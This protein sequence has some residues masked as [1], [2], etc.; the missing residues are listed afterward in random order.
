MRR[1]LPLWLTAVVPGT[2]AGHA[3]AYALSGRTAAGG[4]HGWI[5]PA[6]EVSAAVLLALT[7]TLIGGHL[8]RAR[9]L[10]HTL[11]ERSATAL[12]PRLAIGQVVLFAAVERAEGTMPSL[13]GFAAQLTVALFAAV[14]LAAFARVLAK[15][16]RNSE[17]ASRYLQRLFMSACRFVRYEPSV[18]AQ[19]LA[20]RRIAPRFARPPP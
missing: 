14:L 9:V 13:I 6:S 18:L 17:E 20:G 2:I 1:T 16:A 5:V 10:A 8:L 4:H 15:C 7:F 19:A 3:V 12:W 11:A